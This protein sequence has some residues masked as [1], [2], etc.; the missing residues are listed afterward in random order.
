MKHSFIFKSKIL[1][2][3]NEELSAKCLD[4]II[5]PKRIIDDLVAFL[6]QVYPFVEL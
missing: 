1:N 5:S 6:V 4:T 3:R 2:I